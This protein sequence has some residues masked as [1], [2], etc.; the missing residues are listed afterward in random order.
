MK[1]GPTTKEIIA[2][3]VLKDV[4]ITNDTAIGC[5]ELRLPAQAIGPKFG[6]EGVAFRRIE[7]RWY[8]DI[9]PR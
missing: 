2:S 4:K 9:D 1:K 5:I 7:N 8:C 6:M 3:V